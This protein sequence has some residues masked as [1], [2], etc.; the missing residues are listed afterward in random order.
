MPWYTSTFSF[1]SHMGCAVSFLPCLYLRLR[2]WPVRAD[3][4]PGNEVL[5]RRR[6]WSAVVVRPSH[7]LGALLFYCRPCLRGSSPSRRGKTPPH[8]PSNLQCCTSFEIGCSNIYIVPFLCHL[9]PRSI[10]CPRL[11]LSC[12]RGCGARAAA[13]EPQRVQL[14]PPVHQDAGACCSALQPFAVSSARC[15]CVPSQPHNLP[16]FGALRVHGSLTLDRQ[17]LNQMSHP[18][19]ASPRSD[20]VLSKYAVG[21]HFSFSC[22][23]A[24]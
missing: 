17:H 16:R 8:V 7:P 12:L 18:A 23:S 3:R 13:G 14:S 10:G 9:L 11:A 5:T 19:P 6:R 4:G 22:V 21:K 24:L 15:C 20:F 2:R 1:V